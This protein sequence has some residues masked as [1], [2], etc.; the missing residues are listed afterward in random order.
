MPAGTSTTP[1]AVDPRV[2]SRRSNVA[3]AVCTK[4]TGWPSI[5]WTA[6]MGTASA[7]TLSLVGMVTLANMP[8]FSASSGFATTQR[9]WA[10]RVCGSMVSE[11]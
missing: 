11:T 3:G 1:S 8:S 9:T 10:A 7:A 6:A 5:R 2:T 4:T